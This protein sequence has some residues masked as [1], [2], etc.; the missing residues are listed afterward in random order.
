MQKRGSLNLVVLVAAAIAIVAFISVSVLEPQI[1]GKVSYDIG[2]TYNVLVTNVSSC[3][4]ISSPGEYTLNKSII[5]S[6]ANCINITTDDVTLDCQGYSINGTGYDGIHTV[7][8]N[9]VIIKNCKISGFVNGICPS[10]SGSVTI[11]NNTLINNARGIELGSSN[12]NV[13]NNTLNNNSQYGLFLYQYNNDNNITNNTINFN[14][15]YGVYMYRSSN[16]TFTSNIINNN[17]DHGIY[18]YDNS[19]DNTFI[20]NRLKDNI[21][22]NVDGIRIQNSSNNNLIN[23]II[24]NSKAGISTYVGSTGS[25]LTNNTVINNNLGIIVHG[26]SNNTDLINNTADNNS[27][28]GI[29]LHS[30]TS[31]ILTDNLINNSGNYGLRINSGSNNND[32]ISNTISNSTNQDIVIDSSTDNEFYNNLLT[33]GSDDYAYS[34]IISFTKY[35]GNINIKRVVLQR[36]KNMFK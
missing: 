6:G 28:Y 36:I 8:A 34:T 30:S 19:D 4:I 21:G 15:D 20:S 35:S 26:G 16:N 17:T 31:C 7:T 25:I 24:N 12:C 27:L 10:G 2:L 18:V 32:F 9:N 1:T 23:N 33:E 29:W 14:G 11:I 5:I 13:I 22:S 3:G